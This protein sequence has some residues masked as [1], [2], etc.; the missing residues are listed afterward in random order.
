MIK[1]FVFCN[2]PVRDGLN[3]T[4]S[5]PQVIGLASARQKLPNNLQKVPYLHHAELPQSLKACNREV[6][7]ERRDRG[8]NIHAKPHGMS[9]R[10]CTA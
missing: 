2:C 8:G 3:R 10:S 6:P 5:V 1:S 7:R 4:N 9:N